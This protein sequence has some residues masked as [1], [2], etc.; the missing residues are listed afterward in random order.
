MK[1]ISKK[2]S[3]LHNISLAIGV[4]VV[5][6][7]LV[8]GI[9]LLR[10]QDDHIDIPIPTLNLEEAKRGSSSIVA[11]LVGSTDNVEVHM[12]TEEEAAKGLTAPASMH[13]IFNCPANTQANVVSVA[14]AHGDPLAFQT[15]DYWGYEYTGN[16]TSN[17]LQGKTGRDL[18]EGR[19]WLSDA[20]TETTGGAYNSLNNVGMKMSAN[21]RYYVMSR[22]DLRTS[23]LDTD[24]DGLNNGR[25]DLNGNGEKDPN[26]T[27]PNN[28]DTDGGGL[29]DLDEIIRGKDSHDPN[30]DLCGNAM[31]DLGEECDDGNAI[32]G[33]GCDSSCMREIVCGN[34]YVDPGEQC[35]DGNAMANDG[36]SDQCTIETG[37]LCQGAPSACISVCG[38]SLVRGAEQC[39]DGN[40]DSQEDG[41]S[42]YCQVQAGWLCD[43]SEPS[44]CNFADIPVL[45][46]QTGDSVPPVIT[47]L[48]NATVTINVDDTYIDAG[49]TALD[50]VDGN[51]TVNIVTVNQVDTSTEGIYAVTY[52]VTDAAGN[53]AVQISRTV[54]VDSDG[55]DGSIALV[56]G[57]NHTPGTYSP[58]ANDVPLVNL[59]FSAVEEAISVNEMYV[60]IHGITSTGSTFGCHGQAADTM[61]EV[62]EDVEIRNIVTGQVVSGIPVNT[63]TYS[64][65]CSGDSPSLMGGTTGVFRFGNFILSDSSTWE[66]RMDFVSNMPR[67]GDQFRAYVCTADVEDI[68][69][70]NFGGYVLASTQ[71]VLD[72]EVVSTGEQVVDIRPGEDLIGGFIEVGSSSL[73]V[74]E[75]AL[76]TSGIAVENQKD[77][78]LFR[79]EATAMGEDVFLTQ[80]VLKA[81]EGS[82]VNANDYTLWVDSND[83]GIRDTVLQF[84][85]YAQDGKVT[86]DEIAGGGYIIPVGDTV[87]F[88]VSADISGSLVGN[89]ISIGFDDNEGTMAQFAFIEAETN[90][91]GTSLNCISVNPGAWSSAVGCTQTNSQITVNRTTSKIYIL[92]PQGSLFVTQDTTPT[93]NRQLLAGELGEAILR[94]ELSAE[95]EP[96]DVTRLIFTN[97][98]VNTMSINR[99]NLYKDGAITPFASATRDRCNSISLDINRNS[100]CAVMQSQQLVVPE[101][102]RIDILIRPQMKSDEEGVVQ[103]N[104][105]A[106]Q[107]IVLPV[108][109]SVGPG[110]TNLSAQTGSVTARGFE[111]SNI[112][113]SPDIDDIREG[114]VFVGTR[115]P[116]REQVIVGNRNDI[117][118][119]KIVSIEDVNTAADGTQVPIGSNKTIAEFRFTAS[120]NSNTLNG[121]NKATLSGITFNVDSTNVAFT[122]LSFDLFNKQD[123]T[124][125]ISCDAYPVDR[126]LW[127]RRITGIGSGSMLVD[128][129]RSNNSSVD[130]EMYSGDSITLVLQSAILNNQLNG[131]VGSALQVSLADFSAWRQNQIYGASISANTH[132]QW[133]D[134]MNDSS[135]ILFDWI[136]YDQ[137]SISS[138]LYR[139]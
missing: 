73:S 64:P 54:T 112:L 101:G 60:L 4:F 68:T 74:T 100:F 105:G 93:R 28:A 2:Q 78:N 16:E 117:V 50:N 23:C 125:E 122:A 99:L 57:A 58:R 10:D 70:C 66:L 69:G 19:F 37:F 22:V 26:E 12:F 114:E 83:D 35:D 47:L 53:A 8:G 31:I 21:K 102:N 1:H 67:N 130:L 80:I 87:Q 120:A 133:S 56:I 48:G 88:E 119:A 3:G 46:G 27:D 13:T 126:G 110:T 86:F 98:G 123:A 5:I 136:E 129:K 20:Y 138:T 34:G 33:D 7:I 90:S 134:S 84:S 38:D 51:I 49:A 108:S 92:K 72:A 135:V 42:E 82:I 115:T 18:F 62:I 6:S 104:T 45:P 40:T 103:S 89:E 107:I 121:R 127:T 76:G 81:D 32:G 61:M 113:V 95:D 96:I 63:G 36:C 59:N 132:I 94:L 116:G 97:S 15:Q 128:C 79:F 52:N 11:R 118:L 111:S 24:N 85:D 30:D 55:E 65:L 91:D 43:N 71:Y 139:I 124:Q 39:D 44:V 131:N 77:V 106:I 14:T 75:Q 25:E 109:V 17:R 9:A 41:C 29:N 137:S